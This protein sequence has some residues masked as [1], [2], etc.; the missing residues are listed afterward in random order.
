MGAGYIDLD[1]EQER[2][3]RRIE[4][5]LYYIFEHSKNRY[6]WAK[7]STP[8]NPSGEPENPSSEIEETVRIGRLTDIVT[9]NELEG[10][11]D[12]DAADEV[13]RLKGSRPP[14]KSKKELTSRYAEEFKSHIMK[15]LDDNNVFEWR[16][17][18]ND[19]FNVSF[20]RFKV[21]K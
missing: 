15:N 6:D 7:Y 18:V 14:D 9:K 10:H 19:A 12:I 8:E 5:S 21:K 20:L 13:M 2:K 17:D 16:I 11:A 4:D 1:T 3:E